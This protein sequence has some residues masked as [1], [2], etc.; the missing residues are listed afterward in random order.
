MTINKF[1]V[2]NG[3]EYIRLSETIFNNYL[4][5]VSPYRNKNLNENLY[6]VCGLKDKN[7]MW[8]NTCNSY[9]GSWSNSCNKIINILNLIRYDDILSKDNIPNEKYYDIEIDRNADNNTI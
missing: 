3:K 2:K 9:I 5:T 6:Q 1:I 4:N 8:C 7:L